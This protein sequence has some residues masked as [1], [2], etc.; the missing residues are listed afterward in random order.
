ML[1]FENRQKLKDMGVKIECNVVVGQTCTIK[2]LMEEEG[3]DAVFVANGAGLPVFQGIP[4]ENL[5][6]VYSANEYLTRVNLMGAWKE[7]APTPVI[8]AANVVVVGGGVNG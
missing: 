8:P 5:K 1:V 3:F 7:N 4:G 6:G 2:E